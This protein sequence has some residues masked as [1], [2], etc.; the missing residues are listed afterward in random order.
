MSAPLLSTTLTGTVP[1]PLHIGELHTTSPPSMYAET[2]T[3]SKSHFSDKPASAPATPNTRTTVPPFSGPRLGTMELVDDVGATTNNADVCVK[4]RPFELKVTEKVP[5]SRGGT[6]HST[7]DD[8][9]NKASPIASPKPQLRLC[10]CTKCSPT[11]VTTWPST[12]VS[13]RDGLTLSTVALATYM[14]SAS[15][16]VKSAPPFRVTST[17]TLPV[18]IMRGVKHTIVLDDTASTLVS[19]TTAAPKRH[20]T[21]LPSRFEPMTVTA[22]P[23]FRGPLDGRTDIIEGVATYKNETP[24]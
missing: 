21:L 3:L 1:A 22:E 17:A 23:P 10:V 8:D 16:A 9:R 19:S 4:S 2:R 24:P 15:L 5:T 7:S 20:C 12:P 14:Y 11:T 18:A 13:P 6:E